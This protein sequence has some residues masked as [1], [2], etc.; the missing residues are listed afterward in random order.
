MG[1]VTDCDR[2]VNDQSCEMQPLLPQNRSLHVLLSP[3]YQL[4]MHS[5]YVGSEG[6]GME[7]VRT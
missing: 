3:R 7:H 2:R 6:N 4:A 1:Q 5:L